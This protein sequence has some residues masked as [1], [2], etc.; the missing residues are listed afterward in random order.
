MNIDREI[1]NYAIGLEYY[2]R[3]ERLPKE[4]FEQPDHI[5]IKAGN[6]LHYEQLLLSQIDEGLPRVETVSETKMDGRRIAVV[7][8]VGPV[9]VG[10]EWRVKQLEVMEPRPEMV[11]KDRIGVD[12][13]EFFQPDFE[14]IEYHLERISGII[15]DIQRKSLHNSLSITFGKQGREVKFTD[16]RLADVIQLELEAEE[17]EIIYPSRG[18]ERSI[19]K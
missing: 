13:M 8:F 6:S 14:A 10:S 12:H 2:I 4:W 16:R 5:A 19:A 17:T 11:G 18:D 7:S 1:A 3:R 9:A 15:P